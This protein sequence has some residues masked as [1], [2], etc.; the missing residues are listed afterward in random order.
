MCICCRPSVCRLSVT[1]VHPTQPVRIFDNVSTP[2]GTLPIRWYPRKI[3]AEIVPLELP[4]VGLNARGPAKAVSRKRC[5]IGGKLVLITNRKSY[6]SFRLVS[7]SVAL[8]DLERVMALPLFCVISPNLVASGA[9]CVK[10][11]EDVVVENSTFAILSLNEFL[12]Q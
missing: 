3:F 5:K 8:N 12:V 1:L 7:K 10:M 9:H 11:V 2:L 6:M 4:S